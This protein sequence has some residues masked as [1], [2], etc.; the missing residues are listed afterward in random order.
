MELSG[1]VRPVPLK[2]AGVIGMLTTALYLTVVL[3]QGDGF[4]PELFWLVLMATA[5]L[6]AW[7][8]DR[9]AGRRGAMAAAAIFFVLGLVSPWVLAVAFLAAVV[10]CIVGFVD[11]ASDEH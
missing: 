8:A 6:L 2:I 11:F 1:E 10:L 9:F 4:G 3:N 5:A 7:Y